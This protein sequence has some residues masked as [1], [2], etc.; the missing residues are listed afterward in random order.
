MGLGP[1]SALAVPHWYSPRL[2]WRASAE[3]D[4]SMWVGRSVT[5]R[6][7]VSRRLR[8]DSA[9]LRTRPETSSI[10]AP[11]LRSADVPPAGACRPPRRCGEPGY[12]RDL[13]LRW[14]PRGRWMPEPSEARKK[15]VGP[16]RLS[17]SHPVWPLGPAVGWGGSG[18]AARVSGR[19]VLRREDVQE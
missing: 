11:R 14:V 16:V 8:L 18:R 15:A 19:L 3:A 7:T 10:T 6:V 1:R 4:D 13:P 5:R 2:A 12:T 17:R 9:A